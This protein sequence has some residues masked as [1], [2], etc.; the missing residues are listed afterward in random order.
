MRILF[1]KEKINEQVIYQFWSPLRNTEEA[2]QSCSRIDQVSI[3]IICI[4]SS[5]I[6]KKSEGI[7]NI[8]KT[9]ESIIKELTNDL[10]ARIQ[11]TFFIL[12]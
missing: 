6:I 5:V 2:R 9:R 1:L 3:D 7:I 11:N 8:L 10:V 4:F 12:C